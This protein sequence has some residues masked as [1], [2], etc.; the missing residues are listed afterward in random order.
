MITIFI[1]ILINFLTLIIIIIIIIITVI[2]IT[3]TTITTTTI[4][5]YRRAHSEGVFD[6]DSDEDK[7]LT[8]SASF[9]AL[10]GIKNLNTLLSGGS[11]S[12]NG[13][14]TW[15]RDR[16]NRS[17]SDLELSSNVQKAVLQTDNRVGRYVD[18]NH[19]SDFNNAYR[20]FYH[21]HMKDGCPDPRKIDSGGSSGSSSGGVKA[22]PSSVMQFE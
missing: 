2:I 6:I 8:G 21:Q 20:D 15:K 12:G 19:S 11:G 10:S 4:D 16:L 22:S 18:N 3:T 9:E 7:P 5:W 17:I 13:T 1:L 14:N